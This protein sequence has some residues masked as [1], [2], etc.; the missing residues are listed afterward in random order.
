MSFLKKFRAD[1]RGTSS[2]ELLFVVPIIVWVILSTFVY[3]DAFRTQ[4]NTNRAALT[5]A[6]MFSREQNPV[7]QNYMDG[8]MNLLRAL[9]A[10]DATPDMRVTVYSFDNASNAY[11]I[12]WS[13]TE[14]L[15]TALDNDSL[16]DLRTAGRLPLL[17]D[18]DHAIL[19]ETR[20]VYNGPL[21]LGMGLYAGDELNNVTFNTFNVIRPRYNDRLCY[22]TSPGD[23]VPTNG[24]IC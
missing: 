7:D 16:R 13:R 9:T 4:A 12:L 23:G 11:T 5:I 17:A 20:T 22:D 21:P 6:D 19:L 8:A 24:L 15:N 14:G 10:A 1:E 3:F 18:G 2:I